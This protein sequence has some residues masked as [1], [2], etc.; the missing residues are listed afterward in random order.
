MLK[1]SFFRGESELGP[2]VVP[3]FNRA[4]EAYFEKV[5]SAQLLPDVVRYIESLRPSKDSVYS[6]VNAMG[7]G[8]YFGSNINGD[9]FTEASLIHRPDKWTGNPLIDKIT[10]KDWPYGFPTFYFAHPYAH[11]RNKDASRAFGEVELAV[12]ND[13]MKRVELVTRVD[14]D[15]CQQ[16]GGVQ[17]WDKLVAGQFPDVSMGCKVPFDT[18]SICLDWK[19][20]REAQGTFDPKKHKHQGEA[21]L[22][23]HKNKQKIRGLSIT[24][25][26]Y[27]DHAKKQM[28]KIL[29]DGRKV[30]VYNDYPKFFDI[31]F[32]FIGADK[33]AKTMMKIASAGATWD[34][35]PS[36]EM[37]EKLGYY[38]E[39]APQEKTAAAFEDLVFEAAFGKN[40]KAKKSEIIKDIVPS[41]FAG[42]AV[43][44]LTAAKPDL[45]RDVLDMLGRMPL[46]KSLSTTGSLGLVLRPREFQR[47]VLISVGRPDVADEMDLCGEVFP[48][49]AAHAPLSLG[50][51]HIVPSLIRLLLP[52]LASRS[53]LAPS[54][55]RRVIVM[56]GSPSMQKKGSSSL[57]SPLL[58]KIGAAYNSY[59]SQ[60][61]ELA[62]HAQDALGKA[63]SPFEGE[64]RKLAAA[65]PEEV[66]SPL[67]VAYLQ[68]AFLDELGEERF[69]TKQAQA[70]V[71]RGLPSRNT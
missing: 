56:S 52:L 25:A 51:D 17:V 31:S 36:V 59:R 48:P 26:D 9:Y 70:G 15:K 47:V 12:W 71:E 18:C 44:S 64:F 66:F 50:A 5:A 54:I 6:L 65:S 20:Y 43:S 1:V 37:A 19:L 39:P 55:E 11:H 16:F 38:E 53:A 57:S 42:K 4:T 62:A 60:L 58:R 46:E 33:T 69:V 61:M 34:I 23:F 27:C 49:S 8:E 67:S 10:A 41:Q 2:T 68:T 24:R 40:A 28:N 63:T 29:P 21:V 14:K 35:G 7:A 13:R 32:V 22:Q 30:F 45:P 3:L